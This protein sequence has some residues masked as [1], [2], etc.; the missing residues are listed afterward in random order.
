MIN[1]YIDVIIEIWYFE[2]NVFKLKVGIWGF[3]CVIYNFVNK[4][5]GFCLIFKICVKFMSGIFDYKI[6]FDLE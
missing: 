1:F 2:S 5:G 3:F 6:W 4:E